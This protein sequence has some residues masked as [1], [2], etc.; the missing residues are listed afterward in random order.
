MRSRLVASG[1]ILLLGLSLSLHTGAGL[2]GPSYSGRLSTF[3][4][5]LRRAPQPTPTRTRTPTRTPVPAPTATNPASSWS[6]QVV[7]R[8][9]AERARRGLAALR[10]APELMRSAALHSQDMATH[11]F[12]SHTGSDGS[13]AGER[14]RRT[15]YNWTACAENVAAGYDSPASVVA[16]WMASSGHRANIL[17]PN[18]KDVGAGYAYGDGST[19]GHYWTLNL[20]AR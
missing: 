5:I 3:I 9:N 2:A 19:Y 4:P 20:G 6:E 17:N 11:N 18:Y 10:L 7:A 14:M 1:V 12:I 13:S 15:G 16:G 8:V